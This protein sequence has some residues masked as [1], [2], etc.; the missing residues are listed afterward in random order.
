MIRPGGEGQGRQPVAVLLCAHLDGTGS[1]LDLRV[2]RE[3]LEQTLPGV[4]VRLLDEVCHRPRRIGAA[5]RATGAGRVVLGVCRRGAG[6]AELQAEVRKAGLDPLGVEVVDLGTYAVRVHPR[7]EATLKARVLLAAA[8]ARAQAFTDSRPENL[9]PLLPAAVSRRALLSLS[10]LEYQAVPAVAVERCR[11]EDGCRECLGACPHQALRLE[12]DEIRLDKSRCTSCGTCVAVCPYEALDLPGWTA[13]Q[14]EA[15]IRALLSAPPG[16]LAP[17]AILVM[18]RHGAAALESLASAG[19]SYPVNWFPLEVPSAGMV[20]ATWLL[21]L[22][23]LGAA[24][25]GVVGCPQACGATSGTQIAQR[26]DFCREVLRQAGGDPELVSLLP[27]DPAA[28]L[29]ALRT[30]PEESVPAS[31]GSAAAPTAAN[32]FGHPSRARVLIALTG[33]FGAPS[34]PAIDHPASPFGLVEVGA[35]CTLCGGCAAACGPG[36]LR[37]EG[38]GDVALTFDPA[39]CT[40]CGRCLPACP[41][42]DTLTLH[43]RT[44]LAILSRGRAALLRSPSGRCAACGG[45][46]APRPM[47]ERVA[48]LLRGEDP[49]M[50][51]VVTRYCSACRGLA[52]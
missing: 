11:V 26:V 22:V 52:H 19:A 8:V 23:N 40:A 51:R 37:L 17:R 13:R 35:G 9:K 39:L 14:V 47:L 38:D 33:R 16:E 32:P 44:D 49:R 36:A 7:Q 3:G 10:L 50:L 27:A 41:E 2:V 48:A 24:R 30:T 29:R 34:P 18:C 15:H 28:L 21:S 4:H 31:V 42:P 45:P 25:V 5:V 46:I 12:G 20:P 1:G 43:H 6:A